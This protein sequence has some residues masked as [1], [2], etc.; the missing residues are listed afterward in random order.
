MLECVLLVYSL[1]RTYVV[2]SPHPRF[3]EEISVS[4]CTWFQSGCQVDSAPLHPTPMHTDP[5]NGG[6]TQAWTIT[7]SHPNRRDWFKEC[8][9]DPSKDNQCLQSRGCV[10]VLSKSPR[11]LTL[12]TPHGRRT[13]S[14]LPTD[15]GSL[16]CLHSEQTMAE[17]SACPQGLVARAL[18]DTACSWLSLRTLTF[19]PS[20]HVGRKPLPTYLCHYLLYTRP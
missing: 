7:V 1:E 19:E 11:S 13:L 10:M 8:T 4:C 2:L 14:P 15:V 20:H 16:L 18:E 6:V 5:G 9:W 17:D 12:L 3:S